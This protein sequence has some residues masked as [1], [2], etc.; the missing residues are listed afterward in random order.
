M[1]LRIFA[2]SD[3]FTLL[4]IILALSTYLA[5]ARFFLLGE[6][7]KAAVGSPQRKGL[8]TYLRVL[9]LPDALMT[10]SG[11]CLGL[12]L[13]FLNAPSSL[14]T[15]SIWLFLFAA[16]ILFGFHVYAWFKSWS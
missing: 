15:W 4:A 2:P 9:T 7:K 6:L 8:H 12:N 11:M 3:L 16:L 10:F 5:A 14:V 13:L 1:A